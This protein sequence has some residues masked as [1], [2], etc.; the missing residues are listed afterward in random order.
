MDDAIRSGL[1]RIITLL[2]E[3]AE[4]VEQRTVPPLW[5]SKPWLILGCSKSGFY[6]FASEHDD[7]RLIRLPGVGPKWRIVDLQKFSEKQ[8]LSPRRVRRTVIED[9]G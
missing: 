5:T 3:I 2:T 8:K 1:E 7:L 6:R 9:G 4:A